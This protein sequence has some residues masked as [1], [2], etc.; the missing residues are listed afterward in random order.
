L[1]MLAVRTLVVWVGLMIVEAIHGALRAAYLI[2]RIGD[3]PA[4]RVGVVVGSLL[5]L[6]VAFLT[7]RWL[8]PRTVASCLGV[9]LLWV[10]LTLPFEIALGRYLGSSWERIGADFNPADGGWLSFGLIFMAVAPLIAW[11]VRT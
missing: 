2:P 8:G 6:V 5:I 7:I 3:L 9:G 1:I 4:R 11:R 10:A